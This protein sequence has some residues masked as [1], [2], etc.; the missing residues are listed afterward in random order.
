MWVQLKSVQHI[1]E[2]GVQ[3]TRYPGD[4]V[5]IGKQTA[6]L[7]VGKGL[8]VVPSLEVTQALM[9][10]GAG[11]LV[12]GNVE[13]ARI[14]LEAYRQTLA[15]ETGEPRAA[16][17]RTLIWNTDLHLRL[18][19]VPVGMGLLEKWEIACPILSYERLAVHT[20]AHDER[21]KTRQV[22]RDL[23]VPLYDTRLIFVRR[24]PDTTRLFD[25]WQAELSEGADE[26]HSFL[27]ALY[28]VKPFVLA[29]PTTWTD[30]HAL[31]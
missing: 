15:I 13:Q 29:L 31:R 1:S 28:T 21:E 9:A 16:Y 10:D 3:R 2:R 22:V 5:D 7:W 18:E 20:A 4:W 8:A 24:T 27:R 17:N 23:R 19:L 11:V 6:M 25:L 26:Q 14:L 30:S 12:R